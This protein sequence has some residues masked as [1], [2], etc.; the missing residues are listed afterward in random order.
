MPELSVCIGS[1]CHLRGSY[2]VIQSFQQ[3]IEEYNLHDKL[4]FKSAFCMKECNKNGVTVEFNG[5]KYNIPAEGSR[6]F[7]IATILPVVQ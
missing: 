1:A 7:F 6:D 2:N 4:V 5:T 3:L